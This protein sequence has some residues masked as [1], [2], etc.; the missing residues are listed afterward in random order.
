[1]NTITKPKNMNKRLLDLTRQ[2]FS[3]LTV[4]AY[5]GA[6]RHHHSVWQCACDCGKTCLVTTN[7]LRKRRLATR[8]CGCL[9]GGPT[10]HGKSKSPT[11]GI[12]AGLKTRCYNTRH[13]SYPYYGGRGITV[14]ERWLNSF[15]N[16][17]ADMG[18]CP[19][20]LSLDRIDNDGNY[21]PSNCRWA[22]RKEQAVNN[23]ANVFIDHE[24]ERWTRSQWA[25]RIGVSASLL[26][27]H[28]KRR[29]VSAAFQHCRW[30]A[31]VNNSQQSAREIN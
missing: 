10:T 13:H 12:W 3:L 9:R 4:V 19:P 6:D 31:Q 23:R 5:Q 27:Y 21:E 26:R 1:M 11:F 18:E 25:T 30:R 17:V 15:E 28:L 20:E 7:N 16:F 2:R 24:G 22:T 14:C 8:S 29:T